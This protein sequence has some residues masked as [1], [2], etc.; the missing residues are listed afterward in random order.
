M[1]NISSLDVAYMP[2]KLHRR[3][4]V[5]CVRHYLQGY[6]TFLTCT[7]VDVGRLQN[8]KKIS[9]CVFI[10]SQYTHCTVH[11]V[12][13]SKLGSLDTHTSCIHLTCGLF[14]TYSFPFILQKVDCRNRVAIISTLRGLPRTYMQ[15]IVQWKTFEGEN[16]REFR[17]FGSICES[18]LCEN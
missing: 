18:F 4:K 3:L 17:D 14:T 12:H 7:E 5:E 16:F 9:S 2:L 13:A 15:D 6:P 10:M 11:C 1:Y 8:E